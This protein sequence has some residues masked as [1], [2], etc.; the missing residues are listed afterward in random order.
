M[1]HMDMT[2]SFD[3]PT[4]FEQ[5]TGV[6]FTDRALLREAFT[7]RSYLNEVDADLNHNE[8]LEFLG[9][10]VLELIT[11]LRLYALFPD[12][13]EGDLTRLRSMPVRRETLARVAETLH[14]GEY[15]LLGRGEEETGGRK[16]PATLCAVYE[17]LAGAIYLDQGME[18]TTDFVLST[19]KEDL[20]FITQVSTKLD[21]KSRLQ[22][23][24]QETFGLTPRYKTVR[25]TGPDHDRVFVVVVSVGKI[26]LGIGR[27]KSKR[28]AAQ[29]AAAMALHRLGHFVREYDFEESL[30]SE[31]E[32]DDPG[33]LAPR[34]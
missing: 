30:A 31:Y 4:Y 26:R 18:V 2:P 13:S 32:L 5:Q 24:A 16:R 33:Q 17:A 10:A 11:S 34:E 14:L 19:L 1:D 23:Y 27:G 21:A 29:Q 25:T 3:E 28:T 6:V 9:D 20:E 22:E 15:L 7:H 12:S 8:R